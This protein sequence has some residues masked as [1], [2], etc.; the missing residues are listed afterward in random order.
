LYCNYYSYNS[1]FARDNAYITIGR[2]KPSTCESLAGHEQTGDEPY[3]LPRIN[4]ETS[5]V[6]SDSVT[7]EEMLQYITGNKS[8]SLKI[9]ASSGFGAEKNCNHLNKSEQHH[10]VHASSLNKEGLQPTFMIT[11]DAPSNP[12]LTSDNNSVLSISVSSNSDVEEST[13]K[14][15]PDYYSSSK[16]WT[17]STVSKETSTSGSIVG[18]SFVIKKE[19]AVSEDGGVFDDN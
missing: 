2:D 13:N 3:V 18:Q 7:D 15:H 9:V 6:F 1:Q 16:Q 10:M 5:S 19:C 12:S 8:K 11:N 17:I 4:E 14:L